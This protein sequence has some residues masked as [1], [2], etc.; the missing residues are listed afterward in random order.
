M[1][2]GKNITI[3]IV[4]IILSLVVGFIYLRFGRIKLIKCLKEVEKERE[5]AITKGGLDADKIISIE[6]TMDRKRDNCYVLYK[7]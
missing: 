2:N 5:A 3:F 6:Q 1:K 7:K 4:S